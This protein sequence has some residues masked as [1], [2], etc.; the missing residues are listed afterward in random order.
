MSTLAVVIIVV[1]LVLLL[2]FLGGYLAAARRARRPEVEEHIRAADRALEQARASDRGWERER[3]LDVAAVALRE[4]DAAHDWTGIELVLVDDR[5]GV[6]ED[7]AHMVAA[8]P[9]GP[10]RVILARR[11][12]GE[13]FAEQV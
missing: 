7:R 11:E 13:W 12:G 4:H 3:M 6:T 5:P 1:A 8:G 2:L 9:G 10:V